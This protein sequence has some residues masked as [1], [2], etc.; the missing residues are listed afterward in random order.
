[1]TGI[2]I[3]VLAPVAVLCIAWLAAVHCKDANRL[4]WLERTKS[5]IDT[6]GPGFVIYNSVNGEESEL[7]HGASGGSFKR[8]RPAIDAAMRRAK[9][10]NEKIRQD[11]GGAASQTQK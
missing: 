4:D 7:G 6:E 2:L 10:A 1:M 9:A 5:E 8:L 11:A 3:A